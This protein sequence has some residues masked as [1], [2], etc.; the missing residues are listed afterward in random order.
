MTATH[1]RRIAPGPRNYWPLPM[2]FVSKLRRDP[3][4][5]EQ[6]TRRYGPIVRFR[7]GIWKGHLLSSPDHI[8]HVLQDNFQNYPRS[9]FYRAFE[10]LIGKGLLA[11]EGASW[12]RQRQMIQ[13]TFHRQRMTTYIATMASATTAMLDRWEAYARQGQPFDLAD[14]IKR[15]SLQIIGQTL[16]GYDFENDVAGLANA[17]TCGLEYCTYRM[18]HMFA[19]PVNWPTKRNREFC[20]ARRL[21]DRAVL[22]MISRRREGKVQADD[23]LSQLLDARLNANDGAASEQMTDRQL[24][25]EVMTFVLT[26]HET[27]ASAAT[28][29]LYLLAQNPDCD[30]R[31]RDEVADVPSNE[32]ISSATLSRLKY[33]EMAVSESMRL[34]P[35]VWRISRQAV[36]DDRLGDFHIPAGSLVVLC[37][38]VTHR[39]PEFWHDP[40][41]FNPDRFSAEQSA[42]RPRYAYFPFA[43]GPHR[44]IGN[45]FAMLEAVMI[46]AMVAKRYHLRLVPGREVERDWSITLRPRDGIWVTISEVGARERPSLTNFAACDS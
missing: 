30:F 10:P 8:K 27:V 28:W 31:L 26:G 45:E 20:R 1:P 2:R 4:F 13:P 38:Y 18:N 39:L 42:G 44:C 24:C 21:L 41:I 16:C 5:F 29:T 11:N 46:V 14:E 34:Y 36:N 32:S 15:L 17:T 40:D 23:L 43:G 9:R 19:P 25:D 33:A 22:E 12:Q 35:P 3:F 7:A 6:A 37:P